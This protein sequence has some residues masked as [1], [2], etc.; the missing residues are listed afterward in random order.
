MHKS[1]ISV[2]RSTLSQVPGLPECP[3]GMSEPQWVNLAFDP[4]CHVGYNALFFHYIK[5][6]CALISSASLRVFVTSNGAFGCAYA[7]NVPR[8]SEQTTINQVS[9]A[10]TRL[11]SLSERVILGSTGYDKHDMSSPMFSALVPSRP[12]SESIA[13]VNTSFLNRLTL[14][15]RTRTTNIYDPGLLCC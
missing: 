11:H 13:D 5:L 10:L 8:T 12:S 2:W 9:R 1:A 15:C 14:S 6:D 4:H 7:Q 3:P